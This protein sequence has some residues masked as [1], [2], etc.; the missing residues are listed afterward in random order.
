VRT[1]TEAMDKLHSTAESHERVM[2]VEV[3]GRYAGW[4]ALSSGA[5]GSADVILLPE[6][7]FDIEK[8]CH[9]I[10]SRE[11]MGRH[12]SIVVVAEGARAKDGNIVLAERRGPGTSDRLGGIGS[13]VARA[14]QERTGKEVRTMVLGHLQR[15]GTP[16]TYDRL[17]ALRFGAAAVRAIADR[18]FGV[19]VGLN[20]PTISRVPLAEVVG[21]PKN[22][23]LDSDI[24]ATVRDLGISLGD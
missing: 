18:C 12:F 23:P 13:Q 24:V 22:V 1:A 19:M 4:I 7:P 16:T 20:G 3:M 21:R 8:V 9:K 15:G 6:I 5:S 17:L 10:R 11:A 14:I 2:V